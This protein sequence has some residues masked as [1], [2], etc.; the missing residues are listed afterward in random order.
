MGEE[1]EEELRDLKGQIGLFSNKLQAGHE[2]SSLLDRDRSES[3]SWERS[4]NLFVGALGSHRRA[5]RK[6][7][8]TP[9]ER[10]RATLE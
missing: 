3:Q 7:M 6:V 1:A 2:R 5:L 4:L 8:D 9:K 10:P